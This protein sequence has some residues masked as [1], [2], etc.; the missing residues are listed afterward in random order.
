MTC[1]LVFQEETAETQICV[2]AIKNR[3]VTLVTIGGVD[4]E[5]SRFKRLSG[6]T[7]EP[8]GIALEN[9]TAIQAESWDSETGVL[10]IAHEILEP[11]IEIF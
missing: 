9:K 7:A 3:H 10:F 5:K 6:V 8:G 1:E 2:G 4:V 11:L